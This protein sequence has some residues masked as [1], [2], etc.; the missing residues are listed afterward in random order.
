MAKKV[1]LITGAAGGIGTAIAERLKSEGFN[2]A[3]NVRT[4]RPQFKELV[5]KLSDESC[6]VQVVLGDISNSEDCKRMVEE[7]IKEQ[8]QI[9]VLVNNAGI[10][11]DKFIMQMSEADFEDVI[12]NNLNSAFYLSKYVSRH[13]MRRKSGRIINMSSIVGLHGNAGQANYAA[14]K[15]GMIGLTKSFAKE[16]ASR[17]ILVNAIAPGFIETPMTDNL[18]DDVKEKIKAGIPLGTIG[19]PSDVANLTAFL[20]GKESRYITGQVISVDGGMNV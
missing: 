4:M 11:R 17:N 9:D 19:E 7:V 13:M 18:T 14:A 8:G 5:G 15:A 2:L 6:H 12:T 1:A 3:L 10:T 20:A 16:F